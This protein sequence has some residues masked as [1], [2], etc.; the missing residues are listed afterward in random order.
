MDSVGSPLLSF[1][2]NDHQSCL[3][4]KPPRYQTRRNCLLSY[5]CTQFFLPGS[6][7]RIHCSI[8][9]KTFRS[10]TAFSVAIKH[11]IWTN[12]PGPPISPL[13]RTKPHRLRG[14]THPSTVCELSLRCCFIF[15]WIR[16]W[17]HQYV[18]FNTS[19]I[20]M[21]SFLNQLPSLMPLSHLCRLPF[22]CFLHSQT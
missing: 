13:H 11:N 4:E 2:A 7:H 16:S 19:S 18:T 15:H 1:A 6:I 10:S 8:K 12:F 3:Y 5:G 21:F 9:L 17:H 20:V 22:N 14:K